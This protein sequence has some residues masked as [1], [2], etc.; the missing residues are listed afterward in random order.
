MGRL[1]PLLTGDPEK[2]AA[3]E[4]ERLGLH[5]LLATCAGMKRTEIAAT[6][7]LAPAE[8]CRLYAEIY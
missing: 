5:R 2:L 1:V 3:P 8:L 6:R 4:R 7:G